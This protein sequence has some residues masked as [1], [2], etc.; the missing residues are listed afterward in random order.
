M[1]SQTPKDVRTNQLPFEP[2]RFPVKATDL[3]GSTAWWLT[4]SKGQQ[5]KFVKS[6]SLKTFADVINLWARLGWPLNGKNL[7]DP[8][9]GDAK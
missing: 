6:Y 1:N 9:K 3:K 8:M 2:S 4:L 5:T 7:K